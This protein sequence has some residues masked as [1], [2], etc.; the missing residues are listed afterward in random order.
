VSSCGLTKLTKKS[1]VNGL[2]SSADFSMVYKLLVGGDD[3]AYSWYV[4]INITR[5][6]FPNSGKVWKEIDASVKE[7]EHSD[8]DYPW[9]EFFRRTDFP[10]T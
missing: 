9:E 8:A 6:I 4:A 2:C 10:P 7:P 3:D 5:N 1:L